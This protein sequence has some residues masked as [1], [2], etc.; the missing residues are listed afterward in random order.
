VSIFLVWA[1]LVFRVEGATLVP[2]CLVLVLLYFDLTVSPGRSCCDFM[3]SGAGMSTFL[4]VIPV[5]CRVSR[6]LPPLFGLGFF[7]FFWTSCLSTF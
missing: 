5:R 3:K 7:L 1:L 6:K 4:L 2:A